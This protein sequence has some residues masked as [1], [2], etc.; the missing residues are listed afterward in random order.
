MKQ[1][2]PSSSELPPLPPTSNR[3][4]RQF[5]PST[6][7]ETPS[8]EEKGQTQAG[9]IRKP[10]TTVS[11]P[12]PTPPASAEP[13]IV[14]LEDGDADIDLE[15]DADDDAIV[16]DPVEPTEQVDA[17][18]LS[19]A[20]KRRNLVADDEDDDD[21]DDEVHDDD[22]EASLDVILKE[23]LVVEDE[24]D[25][26]DESPDPEDRTEGSTK[27]LPKQPGEFVCQSCFLV[28]HRSQLADKKKT[29]CRDC[30]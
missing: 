7:T 9:P 6:V 1:A 23:R 12:A 14:T 24:D 13:I 20:R 17:A 10:P 30:V 4:H 15:E 26:E 8:R 11:I 5:P 3:A 29:L 18:P 21:D 16:I 25:E 19:S 27:V 28:K 2:L 22:V